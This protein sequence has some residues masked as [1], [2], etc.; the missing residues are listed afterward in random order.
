MQFGLTETQQVLKNSAREFFSAECP[1]PEVRRL[2]ETG[3]AYDAAL[4]QKMAHQGWTG[5]IFG[6]EH[7]GLGLGLVEM[8]VALEE[9]GRVLV[10][11][12]Y[13]S[14]V[15]LA[16]T[17]IDA[18]G[19][20]AQKKQY[21]GRIAKGEARATLAL[22][23]A[24]ARWDA[25]AVRLAAQP[26]RGGVTLTGRKMFVPDAAVA[27]FLVCAARSGGELGLFIVPGDAAEIGRA[28]V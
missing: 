27:D 17:A 5:I 21:L 13:L 2:M 9:M 1:N 20:P 28:H 4:W 12:P 23:E 7:G 8:A 25:D 10:P 14:T 16:G 19:S 22:L 15:L 24:D 6:E 18:A 3:T 26:S 11:G